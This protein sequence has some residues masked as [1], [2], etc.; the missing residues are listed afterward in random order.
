MSAESQLWSRV[1]ERDRL[2]KKFGEWKRVGKKFGQWDRIW[3]KFDE[4]ERALETFAESFDHS[5]NGCSGG[6]RCRG[7]CA[8]ISPGLVTR[9]APG[10]ARV[11]RTGEALAV[12]VP[13][14]EAT[15]AKPSPQTFAR[16]NSKIA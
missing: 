13:A 5:F 12:E 16:A 14:A 8:I 3:K 9:W 1:R 7:A 2:N 15:N 11:G 6:G 4:F 10:E